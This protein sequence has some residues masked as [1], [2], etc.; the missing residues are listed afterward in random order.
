MSERIQTMPKTRKTPNQFSLKDLASANLV[1][2]FVQQLPEAFCRDCDS[3]LIENASFWFPRGLPKGKSV[4]LV[5]SRLGHK[6]EEKASLFEALLTFA[7]RVDTDSNFLI[8]ADGLAID[9]FV[10]RISDLFSIPRV[11][12]ISAPTVLTKSWVENA[13]AKSNENELVCYY[14]LPGNQVNRINKVQVAKD[15]LLIAIAKELRV[16]ACRENGNT[17]KA[18]FERLSRNRDTRVLLKES[19][20]RKSLLDKFVDLG[21]STW[22]LVDQIDAKPKE[23]ARQIDAPVLT[24]DEIDTSRYLLHYTR[25]CVGQW[26]GQSRNDYLDDLIFGAK[27]AS[28]DPLAALCRILATDRIMATNNL[29]RDP[30]RVVCLSQVKL[31]DLPNMTTF[32]SHLSRWDFLPF[33][34][35]IECELLQSMGARPVVYGSEDNWTRLKPVDRPYFQIN[36]EDGDEL[37]WRI[38]KEWRLQGDLIL[39]GVRSNAAVVFVPTMQDAQVIAK[40][41]RWPIVVLS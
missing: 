40:V 32:R 7:C 25:R 11:R 12:F 15:R 22:V 34:I 35:A 21:A 14:E 17:A 6:L 37:D 16:L 36:K 26:P 38:E 27:R 30:S 4:A 23:V 39:R 41:S 24:L 31:D 20:I 5:S 9:E 28:H 13:S 1:G 33:G 18:I 19:L 3:D 2:D 29:T 10:T 8:T